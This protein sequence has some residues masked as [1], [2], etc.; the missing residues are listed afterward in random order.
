MARCALCD[1]DASHLFTCSYCDSAFCGDHRLPENHNCPRFREGLR[2]EVFASDAPET[3]DRRSTWRQRLERVGSKE[4]EIRQGKRPQS[5]ADLRGFSTAQGDTNVLH[6]SSCGSNV[7]TLHQ[8]DECSNHFCDACLP[9]VEHECPVGM[10]K[11]TEEEASPLT[12][13][14]TLFSSLWG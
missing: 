10:V 3:P 1:A 6:C 14:R 11:E 8:C 12:R 13:I 7:D 5:K 2:D 9:V 4:A